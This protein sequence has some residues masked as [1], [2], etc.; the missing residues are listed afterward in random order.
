MAR[1]SRGV[2]APSNAV[3]EHLAAIVDLERDRT[4][5]WAGWARAAAISF[6]SLQ[7]VYFVTVDPQPEARA[8]MPMLL[9][10]VFIAG[11]VAVLSEFSPKLLRASGYFLA[12]L[13]IPLITFTVWVAIP[14]A[15]DPRPLLSTAIPFASAVVV[16]STLTLDHRII[17]VTTFSA[18]ISIT[19]LMSAMGTTVS[20]MEEPLMAL[21]LTGVFASLAVSRLRSLVHESRRRDFAGRYLLGKRL[22]VGGM[23]EVFTAVYSPEGSFERRVAVKR[24]L[25]AFAK[26]EEFLALFRREAELGAL[27]AHPNLVQV[28]DFGRHLDSWFLT[29]ELVE[30][31]SLAEL[32]RTRRDT[33]LPLD[34]GLYVLAEVAEG[35]CYLHEKRSGDGSQ[36]GLVHRDVNAPNVLISTTGE[37][38]VSDFG[39]ARWATTKFTR[40]G[41]VRGK[42]NSMAPEILKGSDPQPASDVF[43]LGVLAYEVLTGRTLF[44]GR[45]EV[46]LTRAVLEQPIAAPSTLRPEI[47][48]EID[49]LVVELLDRAADRRPTARS[50][51]GRLRAIA[52]PHAPYPTG[53]PGLVSA[54]A[55]LQT[56]LTGWEPSP[57]ADT[58]PERDA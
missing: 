31:V 11:V 19:V 7:N 41:V 44:R 50:V 51:S 10:Y 9:L 30:G 43:S 36:V 5:R 34:V 52:P 55:G 1:Y 54:L 17:A 15:T 48:P 56:H 40:V 6:Y 27:L 49:A 23:A 35:L 22:G 38:K 28:L 47:P 3:R 8:A 16:G 18:S 21:L 39:I 33:P 25:P 53:R 20:E 4:L 57:A 42:I 2:P 12:L 26:D 24:V 58:D 29:M 45:S 13:D 14:H 32:L 46:E 37:V